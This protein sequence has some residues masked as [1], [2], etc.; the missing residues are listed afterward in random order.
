MAD[1]QSI[2]ELR[3]ELEAARWDIYCGLTDL[4]HQ[5]DIP[6]RVRHSVRSQ[7]WKWVGGI[8]LA[9][10]AAG[11]LLPMLLRRP[12]RT[13]GGRLLGQ[14]ARQG[15]AVAVPLVMAAAGELIQRRQAAAATPP[16]PPPPPPVPPPPPPS[17]HIQS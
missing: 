4:R 11:K 17:S 13:W 14:M 12:A 10:L 7:P 2:H 16:P 15:A 3:T 8:A 9:G 6:S 1:Q 5:L